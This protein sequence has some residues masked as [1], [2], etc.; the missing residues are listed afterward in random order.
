M[1]PIPKVAK[2]APR[3]AR[4]SGTQRLILGD[5]PIV[6]RDCVHLCVRLAG[7]SPSE[8]VRFG[9]DGTLL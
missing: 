1:I 8:P 5:G 4:C 6:C 3:C 7:V 9:A 2:V